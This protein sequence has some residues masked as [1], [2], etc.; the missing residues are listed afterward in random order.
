[1]KSAFELVCRYRYHHLNTTRCQARAAIIRNVELI[2]SS[3][4]SKRD[5]RSPVLRCA[6]VLANDALSNPSIT[7]SNPILVVVPRHF[8]WLSALLVV[9]LFARQL[10]ICVRD[11]EEVKCGVVKLHEQPRIAL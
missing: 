8:A 3:L 5:Y 2:A 6:P 4:T 9:C 1:M 10:N 11:N 7:C